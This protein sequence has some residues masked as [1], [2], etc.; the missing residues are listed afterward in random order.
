MRNVIRTHT[1]IQLCLEHKLKPVIFDFDYSLYF[2][3]NR[4]IENADAI[5]NWHHL[6][7]VVD[8]CR[9]FLFQ[10]TDKDNTYL[11]I[12]IWRPLNYFEQ[13]RTISTMSHCKSNCGIFNR[14]L[15][16][17]IRIPMRCQY[18]SR[19]DVF[20]LMSLAQVFYSVDCYWRWQL[21]L[22]IIKVQ[23]FQN[24]NHRQK[25]TDECTSNTKQRTLYA[26][27]TDQR[28]VWWYEPFS[29]FFPHKNDDALQCES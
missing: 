4:P 13:L 1:Q 24:A 18:V 7:A 25:I 19:R 6:I 27:Y 15:L 11:M 8:G 2:Y 20:T 22:Q 29:L 17:A 3:W 21:H 10:K 12:I 26:V 14:L 16:L 23:K 28:A 5:D 9:L